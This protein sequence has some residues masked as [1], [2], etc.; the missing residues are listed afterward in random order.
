LTGIPPVQDFNKTTGVSAM[1]AKKGAVMSTRYLT[2]RRVTLCGLIVVLSTIATLLMLQSCRRRPPA[3]T[4]GQV[5]G[6]VVAALDVTGKENEAGAILLP[7]ASVYLKS[8]PSGSIVA[9]SK[10]STDV[11]GY[12]SIPNQPAGRYQICSEADG[13]NDLCDPTPISI[14]SFAVVMTH[15]LRLTPK[16]PGAIIGRALLKNG[17]ICFQEDSAVGTLVTSQVSAH[18]NVGS[19]ISGPI[20][21]NSYGQFIIPKI[22]GPGT[23][24]IKGECA[25]GQG[26]LNITPTAADLFGASTYDLI[27]D[28]SA[29]TISSIV[30]TRSGAA[31]RRANP[32]ETIKVSVKAQDPDGD[33]LHYK[34]AASTAGFTGAD[35][36][37]IE[38]TLPNVSAANAIYVEVTDGKGGFAT[39]RLALQTGVSEIAFSGTVIDRDSGTPVSGA[40]LSIGAASTG[41]NASGSFF[42]SVPEAERYVL[43]VKKPGYALASKVFLDSATG[44]KIL[45][46]KSQRSVINP[47]EGGSG[48]YKNDKNRYSGATVVI[49][50]NSLVDSSGNQMTAPVNL[51]TFPYDIEQPD[52]IPG[53]SGAKSRTGQRVRMETYGAIDVQLTDSGGN[54]VRLAPGATAEITFNI[55]PSFRA[56][57]PATIPLLTYD[58]STGLWVEEDTFTRVGDTY[59]ATVRH[60]SQFNADTV[61]TNTA[62]IRLTARDTGPDTASSTPA[63][64][65]PAFPFTLHIDY[66][67][68]GG[69]RHNDFQVP[70]GSASLLYRLPPNIAVTLQIVTAAGPNRTF[71]V[72]S[73]NAV[74]DAIL[75]QNGAPPFDFSQCNGFD[76]A[77]PIAGRPVVLAVEL[78]PHD[79]PYFRRG[80]TGSDA[81]SIAYYKNVGALDSTTGNPTPARGTFSDWKN[82]HGFSPNPLTP[83]SGEFRAVYFNNGDL[84]LG[85]DMHCKSIGGADRACYVTNFGVSVFGGPQGEP[86]VAIHDAIHNAAPLATVAMEYKQSLAANA[87]SFFVFDQTGALL[88][89]VALDSEGP[90]DIP[91]LCLA[92]HGGSYNTS[93]NNV[94]NA[95]FLPFDVFSFLYDEVEGQTL[96][97]QQQNLRELN[98]I[99]KETNPSGNAIQNLIDG[100]YPCGVGTGGCNAVDTPFSPSGW[101]SNVPLYQAIT[102]PYC[103][104]CHVAQPSVDWTQASQWGSFLTYAIC[105]DPRLMPHAEV[106][107][108]KF[109]LSQSPHAGAYMFGPSP[110]LGG[111]PCPP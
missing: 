35:S 26:Q 16:S 59:K 88:K 89:R 101:S 14:S 104:T 30:A 105:N 62:C 99:V 83:V 60:F 29:P 86:S 12:F 81:R 66:T 20:T 50:Q 110:G 53:D 7:N 64:F 79:I 52:P 57:A 77:S 85:R 34:W 38:W 5:H 17:S 93:T 9:A 18:D 103:R 41:S 71:V 21:A 91:Q 39:E 51:D 109:W 48:G 82:T 97:A 56:S 98:R 111:G 25:L 2:N 94:E 55:A 4:G 15:Q 65:A 10:V 87:V 37:T 92:C 75:D 40:T 32:G 100:L 46:D 61:F 63:R 84:Q 58:E 90:K 36:D 72:N 6:F 19:M 27:L 102:R 106:P 54:P 107:F 3:S 80:G 28:N 68:G 24:Q 42:L 96:A 70:N 44:V 22:P 95:L 33:T 73:G 49:R 31:L 74:P 108:K 1:N 47:R 78:P 13:F 11:H 45:V 76:P 43:N 8:L 23:Y 69:P 67:A